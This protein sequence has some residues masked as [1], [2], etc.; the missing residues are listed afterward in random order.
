MLVIVFAGKK[1]SSFFAFEN[2]K[3]NP[4]IAPKLAAGKMW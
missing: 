2:V 1:K 3:V 4:P